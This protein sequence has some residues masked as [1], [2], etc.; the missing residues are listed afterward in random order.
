ME[1]NN[2][3]ADNPDLTD[4]RNIIRNLDRLERPVV[5]VDSIDSAIDGISSI[6]ETAVRRANNRINSIKNSNRQR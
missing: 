3:D 1:N 6:V 2:S 4:A 5:D